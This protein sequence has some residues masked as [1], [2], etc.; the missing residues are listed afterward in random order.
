MT[1]QDIENALRNAKEEGKFQGM[2]LQSLQGIE[3]TLKG[4]E[5]KHTEQDLKIDTKADRTEIHGVRSDL[6]DIKKKVYM[7]VGA[8]ALAQIVLGVWLALR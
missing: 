1:E 5:K 4:M 6:D 7:A 2:V 3:T 8:V